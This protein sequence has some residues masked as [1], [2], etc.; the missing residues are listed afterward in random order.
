M[1]NMY[2]CPCCGEK[3]IEKPN[4]YEICEVCDWEDDPGQRKYPDDNIGANEISLNEAKAIWESR[5][6]AA[7]HP[8][9]QK[10]VV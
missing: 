9:P 5:N 4:T 7:T 8:L 10:A 2:H 3:T 6:Q 1:N